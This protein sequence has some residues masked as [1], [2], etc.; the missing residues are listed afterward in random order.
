MREDI[1]IIGAGAAGLIAARQMSDQ[2]N[3]TILEALDR[4]GG[5]IQSLHTPGTG[6]LIEAGPEFI[7]GQLPITMQLL[8]EAG[9]NHVP[10]EGRMYRCHHG[11]WEEQ[12]EMIAGWDELID[13]MEQEPT[14]MSLLALLEKCFSA[15]KYEELR[16]QALRFAEG[17]D[18][19]D[20]YKISIKSLA[21]EWSAQPGGNFRIPAGYQSVIDFLVESCC[22]KNV[23]IKFHQRVT[24]IHWETD[25][26]RVTTRGGNSFHASKVVITVPIHILQ[27]SAG[28]YALHFHPAL[29]LYHDAARYI[30]MGPVIKMILQFNKRCWR[31]D[32]SFILG[33]GEIPT[34][35]SPLP[36]QTPV[37]T[38]WAG[39]AAAKRL[40]HC[41]QEELLQIGLGSL[42]RILAVDVSTLTDALVESAV[43]N[44]RNGAYTY[45][46]PGSESARAFLRTPVQDTIFFAGEGVYS[47]EASGT[48]EAAFASG[49]EAAEKILAIHA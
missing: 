39:G 10:V 23:Q 33:E 18:V 3:V 46:M 22:A 24:D 35:W 49:M 2:Y 15:K 8:K 37:L 34:W 32:A 6:R 42:S 47:G 14:D 12:T 28:K 4:P 29:P 17:F 1:L 38:G 26:V 19:A 31:D 16:Q 30:G 7:H 44:W 11:E 41:S 13:K 45:S 9:I 5:R 40:I 27:E 36:D 43:Y 25:R 20:T 48:V 21:R